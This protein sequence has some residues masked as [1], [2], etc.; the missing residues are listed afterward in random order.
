MPEN[1][2]VLLIEGRGGI[3]RALLSAQP[4]FTVVHADKLSKASALA[5]QARASGGIHAVLFDLSLPDAKGPEGFRRAAAILPGAPMVAL[6]NGGDPALAE[7]L[8]I[9]GAQA[10]LDKDG[11]DG[12][13]LAQALRQAVLRSRA[14]ARR[15]RALFDSAP[16]GIILA[17][18]RRV[19]MANP[20]SLEILGR[21]EA[22][23][24]EA[25]ILELFPEDARPALEKALDAAA[26]EIPE[27]RFTARL[28]RPDGPATRCRVFVKGAMLND[29]P[30]VALY[31]ASMEHNEGGQESGVEG[32]PSRSE[33]VRQSLKMEALGR[34][35]GGVAHD[36]NNLLTAING[37]SEHLLSLSGVEGPIAS[38]LKAIRRA[39]DTAAAMTRSLMSFSRSEGDEARTVGVDAAITEMAPVLQ[40]L[41]GDRV[42]FRLR[43][44]AGES[45]VRLEPGQLEQL[46]LNLTVNARDAMPEGG[47]L[48]LSTRL[49]DV[50]G[51]EAFTHLASGTGEHV[52]ITIEDTGTGMDRETLECLFEPFFTTKRGGRGTGLG[53]A[54]VYG[55]VSQARGGISVESGPGR[56]S[57]FR[58]LLA[59]AT[60]QT[61]PEEPSSGET[62][63]RA[64]PNRETILVVEDEPSLR[65]MLVTILERYGFG[66]LEAASSAE[67]MDLVTQRPD[68]VDLVVTDIMLRGEG[69]DEL[70]EALQALKPGLRAV[71]ISGHSLESLAD[72][73]IVVPADAFLEKPFSPAQ[74]AAKVRAVLD[75]A[76]EAS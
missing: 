68:E 76:R 20:V 52:S 36:F 45:A 32:D 66:L 7:T 9:E 48:T 2:S 46:I 6:T 43:L 15:F 67:A 17:A 11:L 22:G 35:A 30:A 19:I 65:E 72:R 44:D 29:A 47:I 59:L 34:L 71:F 41:I 12:G 8:I 42:E 64:R 3:A 63:W 21:G 38:G 40:R 73:G 14:E 74:L 33:P 23:L 62:A 26:G 37:Y 16:I 1:L 28:E 60:V 13:A 50:D 69:G 24:A 5:A 25:S 70:A 56:G 61:A 39:G 58:I 49:A 4:G 10:C 54:T 27:S 31:L 51:S 18:G 53:L 75:A 55:I 57:R